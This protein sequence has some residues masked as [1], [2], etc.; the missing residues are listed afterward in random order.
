MLKPCPKCGS[1][2][3]AQRMTPYAGGYTQMAVNCLVCGFEGPIYSYG[4]PGAGGA[5]GF[6][7]AERLSIKHWNARERGGTS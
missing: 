3:V 7:R 6:N 5:A 1:P 2:N 4:E